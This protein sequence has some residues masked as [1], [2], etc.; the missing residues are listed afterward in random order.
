[1]AELTGLVPRWEWRTFGQ[2]FGS[3]EQVFARLTPTGVQ[4]SDEVYLYAGQVGRV[5]KL[6]DG[7]M[8]VKALKAVD[9]HGLEQWVPVMKE[10]FPIDAGSVHRVYEELQLEVPPLERDRYTLDQ[11]MAEVLEPSGVHEVAISKHRVRYRLGGCSA[12]LTDLEVAGHDLRTIAIESEDPA[13]VVAAVQEAGLGN[14]LN[15]NF[16][17][18]LAA[19][20][21]DE[22]PRFAVIDVGTN[23]VKF[24][25]AERSSDGSW[26]TVVD[27]AEMTRLGEGL[28]QTGSI[29]DPALERTVDAI[30]EMIAEAKE[31]R[32][33][34]VSVVG[35]AALRLADNR[36]EVVQRILA[37]TGATVEVISGEEEG[38]LAYLAVKA[39][40][41]FK[42]GSLVVFDTGGGSS[43]FTF[44]AGDEVS[45]R[46]SVNLGAV[47]I[48]E[49]F[50]L[51]HAVSQETLGAALSEIAA[52]LTELDGRPRPEALVGMG[53]AVTNITAV[54]H[55]LA[56]YDPEIVQGTV[57]DRTEVDRQIEM[58]RARSADDRRSI[59][60]L[61]P[62]R[63]EVIL[64]GACIVRTVME[65]LGQETLT[66]SDRGLRH[67]VLRER[68]SLHSG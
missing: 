59:V 4:D 30:K 1:V 14:R 25:A 50:G 55:A 48:T 35:T 29:S 38:R 2:D 17:Q 57:L 39:E 28:D 37:E 63:A 46:F 12:E 36:D 56:T 22:G 43:Q 32:V 5:V 26:R 42:P 62:K 51:D 58:Y 49:Q 47:R 33:L 9:A 3:A 66:V 60:G 18:G 61:Q 41:G 19:V 54:R 34:V 27:R 23:S 64:A 65:K 15:H 45:E 67:G 7:L 11:L 16:N 10:G 8:D 52:S 68:F 40:L 53:G 20:L 13:A 21:E 31:H 44:G 6:R 24:H